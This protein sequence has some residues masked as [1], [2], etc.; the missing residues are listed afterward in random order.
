MSS[1]QVDFLGD[2]VVG[3]LALNNLNQNQILY[4]KIN[5]QENINFTLNGYDDA[6]YGLIFYDVDGN[7]NV[8]TNNISNINLFITNNSINN[9]TLVTNNYNYNVFIIKLIKRF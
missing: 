7:G 8:I 4:Q 9:K 3:Q 2:I 6:T 1:G 5:L